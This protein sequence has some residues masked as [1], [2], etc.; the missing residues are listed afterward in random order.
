MPPL[1][2]TH[3]EASPIYST[4]GIF[5]SAAAAQW[6]LPKNFLSS[7]IT[8]TFMATIAVVVMFA[9]LPA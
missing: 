2:S 8:F 7:I 1:R 6:E 9:N 4:R 3:W 5:A